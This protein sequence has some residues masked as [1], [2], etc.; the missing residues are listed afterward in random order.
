MG[1]G[2]LN[3]LWDSLV[4]ASTWRLLDGKVEEE[5]SDK[6]AFEKTSATPWSN[7]LVKGRGRQDI[8][9]RW[10]MAVELY[11]ARNLTYEAD[12]L[13]AISGLAAAMNAL[14]VEDVYLAGIWKRDLLRGLSWVPASSATGGTSLDKIPNV[15]SW[16][17]ASYPRGV[18]F[19]GAPDRYL[20]TRKRT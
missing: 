4:Q 17:W 10:L 13:P 20:I 11:S 8:R 18:H 15:P 6:N 3:V 16:S 5:K 14:L 7:R 12:K 2:Q 9:S 1:G 19:L